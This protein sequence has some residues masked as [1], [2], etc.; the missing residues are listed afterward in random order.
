MIIPFACVRVVRSPRSANA[1]ARIRK[2]RRLSTY[3]TPLSVSKEVADAI[4]TNKPVVALETTIYT[5]GK[6]HVE[7]A[8]KSF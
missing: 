4:K 1:A 5:H 6:A 2:N 3:G 8:L 7:S